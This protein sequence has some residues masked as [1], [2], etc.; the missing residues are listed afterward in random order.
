M[1]KITDVRSKLA[2]QLK[3]TRLDNLEHGR[4]FLV[5]GDSTLRVKVSGRVYAAEN[6]RLM[7]EAPSHEYLGVCYVNTELLIT[8]NC[9]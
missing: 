5:R 7:A 1:M 8:S 2:E 4:F 6:F 9:S 3:A